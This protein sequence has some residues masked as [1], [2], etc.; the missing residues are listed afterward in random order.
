MSVEEAEKNQAEETTQNDNTDNNSNSTETPS[1]DIE[2]IKELTSAIKQQT[3][4]MKTQKGIQETETPKKE[5]LQVMTPG[6]H[7]EKIFKDITRERETYKHPRKLLD[8]ETAIWILKRKGVPN[9]EIANFI[10]S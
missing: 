5:E 8:Y 3:E 9:D 1:I 2:L 4:I 10:M 6:D 7:V